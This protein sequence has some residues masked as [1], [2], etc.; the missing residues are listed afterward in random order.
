MTFAPRHAIAMEPLDTRRSLLGHQQCRK[1]IVVDSLG[2]TND[3]QWVAPFHLDGSRREVRVESTHH[4][5]NVVGGHNPM[6]RAWLVAAALCVNAR[7]MMFTRAMQIAV[8]G[9]HGNGNQ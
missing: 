4:V 9:G 3:R 1:F 5:I 6:R 7:R 8:T 2:G